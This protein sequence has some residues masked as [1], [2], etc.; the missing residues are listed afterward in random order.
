VQEFWVF[1]FVFPQTSLLAFPAIHGLRSS[2][3]LQSKPSC[4]C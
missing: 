1:T 3:S 4:L 2:H